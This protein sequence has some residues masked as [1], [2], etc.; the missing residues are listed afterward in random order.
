MHA[1]SGDMFGRWTVLPSSVA[2]ELLFFLKLV[3]TYTVQ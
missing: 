3:I 2:A 1:A